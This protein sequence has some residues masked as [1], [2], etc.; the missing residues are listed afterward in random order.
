MDLRAQ[1]ST[2]DPSLGD[3]TVYRGDR[4]TI[5]YAVP[6]WLVTIALFGWPSL[7]RMAAWCAVAI[8]LFYQSLSAWRTELVIGQLGF[9][10]VSPLHRG[11]QA[12]WGSVQRFEAEGR[13]RYKQIVVNFMEADRPATLRIVGLRT[14]F[15]DICV[16]AQERWHADQARPRW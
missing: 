8:P 13:G 12:L 14:R 4:R 2:P 3:S 11:R 9:R 15:Q 10:Y 6:L 5:L 1:Y 7:L 16:A